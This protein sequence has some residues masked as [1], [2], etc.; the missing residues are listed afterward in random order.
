MFKIKTLLKGKSLRGRKLA[1]QAEIRSKKFG[2]KDAKYRTVNCDSLN[3][4]KLRGTRNF[5]STPLEFWYELRSYPII[6][7]HTMN[8]LNLTSY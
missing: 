5:L 2:R 3:I 7:I 8:S 4:I 1:I 6:V